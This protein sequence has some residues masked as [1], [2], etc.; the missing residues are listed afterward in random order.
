MKLNVWLYY[1]YIFF[2]DLVS[3]LA[4]NYVLKKWYSDSFHVLYFSINDL[5]W[6][7]VEFGNN[8]FNIFCGN[9]KNALLLFS[10]VFINWNDI[11]GWINI[12]DLLVELTFAWISSHLH[13][14]NMIC[15]SHVT[16]LS[17]FVK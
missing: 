15:I 10:Q 14:S 4:T 17:T 9:K 8:L 2:N 3:K 12:Y 6:M 7:F 11:M 1:V 16:N 5:Q 13:V